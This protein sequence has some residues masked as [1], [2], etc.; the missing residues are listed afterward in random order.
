MLYVKRPHK[1]AR[2]SSV[3][4]PYGGASN[5]YIL[6]SLWPA[7]SAES[8]IHDSGR[9]HGRLSFSTEKAVTLSAGY[10]YIQ[11]K[12]SLNTPPCSCRRHQGTPRSNIRQQT[13]PKSALLTADDF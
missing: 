4:G 13:L 2:A 7:K 3:E 5:S 8:T 1:H 12:N 11:V 6:H 9:F 10:Y